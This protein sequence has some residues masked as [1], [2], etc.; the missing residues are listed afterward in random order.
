MASLTAPEEPGVE[1]TALCP[2][3]PATALERIAAL[4]QYLLDSLTF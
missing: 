3:T 4:N 2:I 1:K